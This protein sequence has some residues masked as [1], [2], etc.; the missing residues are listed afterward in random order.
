MT[1]LIFNVGSSREPRFITTVNDAI[2]TVPGTLT[3]AK[4]RISTS[5]AG[6]V[7]MTRLIDQGEISKTGTDFPG[8]ASIIGMDLEDRGPRTNSA[9]AGTLFIALDWDID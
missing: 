8:G 2:L 3:F 5:R 7:A 6:A 1:F 4:I 9:T